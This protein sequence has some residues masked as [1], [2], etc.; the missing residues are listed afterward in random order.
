[1]VMAPAAGTDTGAASFAI[2][3]PH[4]EVGKK[5]WIRDWNTSDIAGDSL[6]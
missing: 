3:I 4:Y 5:S 6:S 1:M 2:D